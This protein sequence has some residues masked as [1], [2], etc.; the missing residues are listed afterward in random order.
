VDEITDPVL[1]SSEPGRYWT[2]ANVGEVTPGILAALDWS[3]WEY[4]E[5]AARGAWYDLGILARKDVYLPA[6]PNERQTAVFFGRHAL[7]VDRVRLAMGSIPGASPD[8]FERD[9][10]GVVREGLPPDRRSLRR[11]PFILAKAIPLYRRTDAELRAGHDETLAWWRRDVLDGEAPADPVEALTE[12][13][14]RF[15]DTMRLHA[16]LRTLFGGAQGALAQLADKAG[17]G[18]LVMAVF[19]GYGG[20]T[21]SILSADLVRFGQGDLDV[22]AFIRR[23]GY[24]GPDEGLVWTRSWRED[25]ASVERLAKAAAERDDPDGLERRAAVAVQRRKAAEAEILEGLPK[26]LRRTARAVFR[27]AGRQV[28]NLELSKATF[29]MA[30]DGC[31]AAARRAGRDLYQNGVLTD[32]EDVFFFTVAELG[33]RPPGRAAE[34]AAYRKA[35]RQRYAA[36]DLPM[37]F[38]GIPEPVV[39]VSDPDDRP[40]EGDVLTGIGAAHGQA[41]GRARI[42]VDPSTADLEPGDILVCRITNPS[43]TPLFMLAEAVVIDIG[44]TASHGAI[45]ARELGLPC[46]I[47]TQVGTT[48]LR[49]GDRIAV[50]GTAG[51]VR[52]MHR[53]FA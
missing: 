33:Q 50:D 51:T 38:S 22:G 6:N 13:T 28:R 10:C 4:L 46:V 41:E 9:V 45:V 48:L 43:W 42:V 35:E 1:G 30:L 44:S 12:A 40:G 21:E 24:L 34:T 29:H 19:A 31:R 39:D 3:V 27:H 47:N 32:P 23:W 15:S 2:F 17:R 18:D 20:V 7:N 8:D 36:M 26:P 52:V 37:M 49:D 5:L 25:P 53:A 16:R 11:L 14:Q